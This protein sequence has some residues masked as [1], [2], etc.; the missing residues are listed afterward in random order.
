MAEVKERN[1]PVCITFPPDLL[2]FYN[3]L[4][5]H[6]GM[7]RNKLIIDLLSRLREATLSEE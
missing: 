3:Q 5:V 6:E 1:I 2:A 4:A 7:G